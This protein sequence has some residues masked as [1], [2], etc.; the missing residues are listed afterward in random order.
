MDLQFG[1]GWLKDF[2]LRIGWLKDF[3]LRMNWLKD[4]QLRMVW[5]TDLQLIM[6]WLKGFHVV[7]VTQKS[8]VDA[9]SASFW[10]LPSRGEIFDIDI[11]TDVNV[12]YKFDVDIFMLTTIKSF[13]TFVQINP[14]IKYFKLRLIVW[15]RRI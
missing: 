4:F 15:V 3:Q 9:H 2:Q 10:P 13:I 8:L 6:G 14:N 1:M 5:L 12:T 11:L 7:E